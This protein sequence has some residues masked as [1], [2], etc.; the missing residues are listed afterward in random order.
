MRKFWKKEL[1]PLISWKLFSSHFSLCLGFVSKN[2]WLICFGAVYVGERS[3]DK[4][5][6]LQIE[7]V[8]EAH[9]AQGHSV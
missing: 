3:Q 4:K 6:L 9:L 1:Y 7:G 8:Q 2:Y 5:D